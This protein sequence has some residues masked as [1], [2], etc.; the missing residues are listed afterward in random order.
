MLLL[1]CELDLVPLFFT[2]VGA[3]L[4]TELSYI[5]VSFPIRTI[6]PVKKSMNPSLIIMKAF[7]KVYFFSIS[8]LSSATTTLLN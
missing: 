7:S 2:S 3:L 5:F 6:V 8:S 4:E 1:K